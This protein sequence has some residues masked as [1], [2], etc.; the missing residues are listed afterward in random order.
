[1]KDERLVQELS[2]RLEKEGC[3][4]RTVSVR[5]V[6][7]LQESIERNHAQGLLNEE[8]YQ[9]RLTH[10]SFKLPD[11][12]PDAQSL[13]VVVAPQPQI[14]VAFTWQGEPRPVIIPPTYVHETDKI[15]ESIL[16][17]VLD[18]E[19]HHFTRAA[20]PLKLLAVRSGLGAYGRNN[21]CYVPGFGSFHRLVAYYMNIPC[22]DDRWR[23]PKMMENC[24]NCQACCRA[25]RAGAIAADRFL[26][27][28]ERCIT[29]HNERPHE[30]PDWI[31]PSWH[32]CLVGCMHC[33]RVCPENIGFRDWVEGDQVFSEEET[34]HILNSTPSNRLP[35]ETAKK[36][37]QLDLLEDSQLLGRNLGALLRRQER[38]TAM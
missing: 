37:E 27:R 34:T 5:C 30:F 1:M 26:I 36:L 19:K 25:C 15:V 3:Q 38:Y 17:D 4:S 12:L 35:E 32:N 8:F 24:Q 7:D 28:A 21:I 22:S 31:D 29:F 33:Q 6:R 2:L 10:F 23:E 20:L 11:T 16:S 18:L 9:E 13:I 14:R